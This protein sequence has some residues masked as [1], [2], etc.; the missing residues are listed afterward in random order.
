VFLAKQCPLTPPSK[1]TCDD[2]ERLSTEALAL[3]FALVLIAAGVLSHFSV[4]QSIKN[5]T[6]WET[7]ATS[8]TT[9]STCVI[10]RAVKNATSAFNHQPTLQTTKAIVASAATFVQALKESGR[11]YDPNLA[12]HLAMASHAASRKIYARE[13]AEK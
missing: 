1:T 9:L 2:T 13:Q 10:V 8:C 6:Y 3:I 4:A 12:M 11:I 7:T 5:A